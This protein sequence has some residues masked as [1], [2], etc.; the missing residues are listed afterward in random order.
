MA[1]DTMNKDTIDQVLKEIQVEYSIKKPPMYNLR[2]CLSYYTKDVL[3]NIA[4]HHGSH[5][6][7]ARRKAEIIDTLEKILLE[8]ITIHPLY[9]DDMGRKTMEGAIG[10]KLTERDIMATNT[11]KYLG[12]IFWFYYKG[13]FSYVVPSEIAEK[14]TNFVGKLDEKI[15]VRN[16]KIFKHIMALVNIYGVFHFERFMDI[17]NRYNREKIDR[18]ELINYLNYKEGLQYYFWWDY[19]YIIPLTYEDEWEYRDFLWKVG[20]REYFI[21]SKKE[22]SYYME[23]EYD[24]TNIYYKKLVQYLKNKNLLNE[25]ELDDLALD[26]YSSCVQDF[27]LQMVMDS[28][29]DSGI[30]FDDLDDANKFLKLF[31]D[32]SN[33]SRKWVLGGHTPREL[34][35][36]H[37]E[38]KEDNIIPFPKSSSRKKTGR[39]E[40]CP[41]GSGRKYKHCCGGN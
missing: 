40:P 20:D 4:Y 26:I 2:D 7:T 3:I 17:W 34:A 11:F 27:P 23:N 8:D 21:P 9:M 38:I 10:G 18:E 31:M 25:G 1:K 6:S 28:V 33:N 37:G 13:E 30:G 24:E 36:M 29:N 41:C 32:L 12:Y 14:Y 39:N 5:I 19:P 16:E 35:L 22:L 15:L